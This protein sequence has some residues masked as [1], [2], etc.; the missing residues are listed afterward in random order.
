MVKFKNAYHNKA[1]I[2]LLAMPG[3][4]PERPSLGLSL[5]K[6]S[7]SNMPYSIDIM[8]ANIFFEKEIE[9]YS[10][11]WQLSPSRRQIHE[12]FFS[13]ILF[14]D[15]TIND[16]TYLQ[17]IATDF[18][19]TIKKPVTA[20]SISNCVSSYREIRNKAVVFLDELVE[21][22][23]SKNPRIVGCSSHFMQHIASL[24]ILKKIKEE[25]PSIIT[26]MGGAN[27]AGEMGLTTVTEFPFIDYIFSGEADDTFPIFVN[28]V[29]TIPNKSKWN[30]PAS[31][32]NKERAKIIINTSGICNNIPYAQVNKL[33]Q[34]PIPDFSDY[35]NTHSDYKGL[36]I[37]KESSVQTIQVEASRGCWWFEKVGC[38]FCGLSTG[39][40]K[41]RTKSTQ[42]LIKELN[43][44]SKSHNNAVLLFS[45]YMLDIPLIEGFLSYLKNAPYNF[46]LLFGARSNLSK[47]QVRILSEAKTIAIQP[48]IESL[49]DDLL[50]L[51]K[52]GVTTTDNIQ[53]LKYAIEYNVK[54]A[55][56]LLYD[57][58]GDKERWYTEMT[59]LFHL[60][61]HL[62]PPKLI[63][64]IVFQRFSSYFSNPEKYN[65]DLIPLTDYKFVYPFD[66]KI[67][68]GI[69]YN[70]EQR[71][72]KDLS[73]RSDRIYN[74]L[75][76]AV[77][78]WWQEY[79]GKNA[80]PVLQMKTIDAGKILITDTRECAV[81]EHHILSINES[82][83]YN[84]CDP[85]VT[86]NQLYNK[87]KNSI[88]ENEIDDIL[89][90]L[91]SKK[92]TLNI[93]NKY[94]SLAIPKTK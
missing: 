5:L 34:L 79:Y 51:M 83:V 14:P 86:K 21:L 55:W 80:R 92:L 94:L 87:F 16:E 12:W 77:L 46:R 91:V 27:C 11:L 25:K 73:D 48:G 45:D 68:R 52:K 20:E 9:E 60:L 30:L 76:S 56:N 8:Y 90:N 71:K 31:I 54:L 43:Y 4:P 59:L 50:I 82:L 1:D 58:P 78:K 38:T 15:F 19:I 88:D 89:N 22:V 32:I 84:N 57:F 64:K 2:V 44:I 3:T 18:L 66:E 24:S 33:D 13:K 53:L 67:L 29:L 23:L 37:F 6:A 74:K 41:Y 69:V 10:K 26:I 42:K 17:D 63:N 81:S 65:L 39:D 49:H 35:F 61:T 7:V 40:R 72:N 75:N 62:Q 47:N 93:K 36:S 28:E 85:S 70:F